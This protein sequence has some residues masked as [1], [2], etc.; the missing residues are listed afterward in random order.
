MASTPDPPV[1]ETPLAGAGRWELIGDLAVFQVKL[2]LD[3]LRD[4]VLSPVTLVVGLV[5][6][7]LRGERPRLFYQTLVMARRSERWINLFG[8]A[9]RIAPEAGGRPGEPGLDGLVARLE[10]TL[11]EQARRGGVT[12]SAKQQID[13]ALDALQS[14]AGKD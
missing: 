13:R 10:A 11:A 4:L 8:A 1:G 14:R 5:D 9:D 2:A 6:L 7:L 3:A 12:A